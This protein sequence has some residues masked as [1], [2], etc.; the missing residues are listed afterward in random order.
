MTKFQKGWISALIDGEGC[1]SIIFKHEKKR[2]NP[3]ISCIITISNTNEKLLKFAQ[4]IVKG[5]L[6]KLKL[7]KNRKLCYLLTIYAK[8]LRLIL[9]LPFIVKKQQQKI[10]LKLL[11]LL[12]GKGCGK[13]NRRPIWKYKKLIKLKKELHILNQRGGK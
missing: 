11:K 1:L 12:N 3:G 6:R 5:T 8:Q 7:Q 2:P 10:L 9:P 13:G 4:K